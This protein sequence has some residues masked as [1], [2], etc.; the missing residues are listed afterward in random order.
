[1][2]KDTTSN[3]KLSSQHA[4][5][6]LLGEKCRQE[7]LLEPLHQLVKI[8]QKTVRP[9]PT[10][11]LQDC[12][13]AI[14]CGI[15]VV[16]EINTKLTADLAVSRAWG[17]TSC[18]DQSSVQ[19]TLARCDEQNLVEL[20]QA[21]A[22]I[23]H[24][25]SLA[26]RHNYTQ[27]PLILDIDMTGLRCSKHYQGASKGYFADAKRGTTGRQLARVSAS[28]YNEILYEQV[29]PGNTPCADL[30]IIKQLLA[31]TLAV[32]GLSEEA[33]GQ[34]LLRLDRGYGTKEIIDYLLA[35]GYQFVVKLYSS[36]RAYKLGR[37][38]GEAEWQADSSQG[39]AYTLVAEDQFYQTNSRQLWQIGVRCATA[40]KA[41]TKAKE[42][43]A[44]Q[45]AKS[46]TQA[47]SGEYTY[48]VLL[49]CRAELPAPEISVV[50]MQTQLHFYDGRA[51]IESASFK[52][53]KQ[54]L[55]L[56][57]R[58]KY[59]LPGQEVLV[60]ISQLAHNLLVWAKAWLGAVE[61]KLAQYGTQRWVR[62]LL[63]IPGRVK[64]KEGQV[65]KVHLARGHK[66]A[67][68]YFPGLALYWANFDIGLF[69][70][71]T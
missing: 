47:E 2:S 64:F 66:L 4:L 68:R 12:L 70:S 53:D 55:K 69:L 33:K 6:C 58:R 61:P 25:Y 71:E 16:S 5:L 27:G 37:A 30:A 29:F 52:G 14:L 56:V 51:S 1:M 40:A 59:S 20:R 21:L 32:L 45:K 60:L 19:E 38:V 10:Q 49:V 18:A 34:V 17:R 26:Y 31:G 46:A 28:Q 35:E 62:D 65:V 57:K 54:G 23:M 48:S 43:T 63:A 22:Q 13:L 36:K 39:R 67:R 15:E 41:E 24:K 50:Q 42:K 8:K 3:P 7:G 9:S 11:K 44:S